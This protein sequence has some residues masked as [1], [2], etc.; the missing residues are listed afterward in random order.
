LKPTPPFAVSDLGSAN[1]TFVN[2]Q[3]LQA[4]EAR[5]LA[6]G[7]PFF[8]GDSALVVRPSGLRPLSPERTLTMEQVTQ[9]LTGAPGALVGGETATLVVLKVRASRPSET[10]WVQAILGDQF[11]PSIDWMVHLGDDEVAIGLRGASMVNAAPVDAAP[12]ERTAMETLGSWNVTAT[13]ESTVLQMAD[14]LGAHESLLQF[15]RGG[16]VVRLQRG[17]IVVGD[18][19]MRSLRQTLVRVA[20]TSMSLLV[21]GET[22]VGKDVV[23]SMVHELSPRA[24]NPFLRLNCAS[25]PEGLLESELFGHERGS[26]TGAVAT[27]IG[28]LEAADGG[29]VFLDEIGDLA[30]PL[31]AKLLRAIESCEITRL[32]AVRPRRIDVRFVAATNRDLIFDVKEKRFRSDLYHRLNGLTVTVPPLRERQVEIEPLARHFLGD[33]CARFGITHADLSSASVAALKAYLWPGNV[34]ELRNVIERGV[35]LANQPL[36]EPHHLGLPQ[37]NAIVDEVEV[38]P[39]TGPRVLPSTDTAS[40]RSTIEDALTRCGGNQRR[41]ADLLKISRRT[42]VRKIK[43]LGLPRPRQDDE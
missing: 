15:I 39:G 37:A 34:R 27:K 30:V 4:G 43:K 40:E 33:A 35:L 12:F 24:A 19:A 7:E 10:G 22:G 42:L 32:G 11:L 3:R 28:L 23:A 18:P 20:G 8:I 5:P 6:A 16:G 13:V 41:A 21:L 36:L 31:Q 1:G 17:E 9:L 2:H 14:P 38:L 29:T 26:F 25:L